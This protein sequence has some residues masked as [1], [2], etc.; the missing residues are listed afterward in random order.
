MRTLVVV[1]IAVVLA[2]FVEPAAAQQGDDQRPGRFS[3]QPVDGGV[4]RLDTQTGAVSLCTGRGATWSC[5][6]VSDQ[7]QISEAERLAAENREL[8]AENH[9]LAEQLAATPPVGKRFEL[10]SER[11]VDA[12]LDYAERMMKR[13]KERLKA[14]DGG[15]GRGTPM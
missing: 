12:A 3:L 13:F 4:L 11:D 2:A 15:S 8:K 10:P 14:F 6:A 9:R 1:I 5:T 7:R